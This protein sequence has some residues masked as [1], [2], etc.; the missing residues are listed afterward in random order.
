MTASKPFDY[1]ASYYGG[2]MPSWTELSFETIST[3]LGDT[4]RQH[5]STKRGVVLDYGC[6]I[7]V[8]CDPLLAAGM[9]VVG[10]DVSPAALE[11]ARQRSYSEVL[12]LT[13]DR[14]P[15]PDG[16]VSVLFTTE[17]LEHI[18]DEQGAV[19]DFSRLIEVGGLLIL[20]TTLYFSSINTYLSTAI[21]KKH[22]PGLILSQICAYVSGFF[23]VRA[24]EAFVKRW[25]FEPLGG[26]FHGFHIR[27]LRRLL[28]RNGFEVRELT[29][30]FIFKP[31]GVG[32]WLD[33]KFLKTAPFRKRLIWTLPMLCSEALNFLLKG[34]KF[35]ANNIFIVARRRA[36][37]SD[38]R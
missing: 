10:V 16:S 7:G 8:Y 19:A 14:V 26:H 12:L 6:G 35:T 28:V 23:S 32:R 9:K 38:A 11:G 5:V 18:E 24:Q 13:G 25:C 27:Q 36:D 4:L 34:F 3:K 17:V 21:I 30:L 2:K 29:P 1:D 22:S 33:P 20:T 31:F 15:L 37:P